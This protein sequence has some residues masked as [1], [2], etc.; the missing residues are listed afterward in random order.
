[1]PGGLEDPFLSLPVI[2]GI[3]DIGKAKAALLEQINRGVVGMLPL[4]SGGK[5][6]YI[7]EFAGNVVVYTEDR[8][9]L[10][11]YVPS[12]IPDVAGRYIQTQIMDQGIASKA[13]VSGD[14]KE[15]VFVG[16][17]GDIWSL[18]SETIQRLGYR[19]TLV[20]LKP[21]TI[22]TSFDPIEREF[23]IADG[24]KGFVLGPQGLSETANLPT[25]LY[26]GENQT[27]VGPTQGKNTEFELTLGIEDFEDSGIKNLS[28][29]EVIH[30]GLQDL[31]VTVDFKYNSLDE[32]RHKPFVLGSPE[33]KFFINVQ[34][35][36]FR[37]KLQATLGNDPFLERIVEQV[38]FVDSRSVRGPRPGNLSGIQST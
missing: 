2:L 24:S 10:L 37:A 30:R 13:T 38:I 33:R 3:S 7:K 12:Q 8:A 26:R 9:H 34:A 35:R 29:L 23:Y 15:H 32:F 18:T 20:E 31:K 5:I 21:S 17:G 11:N 6:L 28:V 27:L 4:L 14:M 22:R 25:S 19:D 16:K 1:L 36:E